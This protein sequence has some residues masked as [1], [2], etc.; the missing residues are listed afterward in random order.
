MN[1]VGSARDVDFAEFF[2]ARATVLRRTA[3]VI[4]QDR[5]RGCSGAHLA[6][7]RVSNGRKRPGN[8]RGCL[9]CETTCRAR[10][11]SRAV[12]TISPGIE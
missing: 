11:R 1:S 2:A 12:L 10:R 7:T 5:V 9:R 6:H 4:V 8:V 3:F